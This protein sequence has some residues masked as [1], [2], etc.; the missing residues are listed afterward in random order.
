[1]RNP[2]KSEPLQTYSTGGSNAL[3]ASELTDRL[4]IKQFHLEA[5]GLTNT[6]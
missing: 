1:M 3:I 6:W 4:K 2:N 5:V